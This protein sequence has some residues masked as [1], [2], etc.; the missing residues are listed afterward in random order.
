MNAHERAMAAVRYGLVDPQTAAR[1]RH[2]LKESDL[3]ATEAVGNWPVYLTASG[4][5]SPVGRFRRE[6][7]RALKQSS[8]PMP[9]DTRHAVELLHIY[10]G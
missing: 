8:R 6:L 7:V 9:A 1:V 4:E 10:T 5:D 2:L 3:D